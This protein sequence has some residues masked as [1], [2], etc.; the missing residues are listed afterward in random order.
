M[1]KKLIE[2]I[3]IIISEIGST[4]TGEMQSQSSQVYKDRATRHSCSLV[5]S[6]NAE[7]ITVVEYVH[8]QEVHEFYA[9]YE[10]LKTWQLKEVLAELKQY[11]ET[12]QD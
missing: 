7:N 1:K 8:E 10:D 5:E 6:Y 12:L 3:K 2:K 9:P 4:S 11:A